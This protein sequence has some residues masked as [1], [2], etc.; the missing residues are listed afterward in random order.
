[1]V[2]ARKDIFFALAIIGILTVLLVPVP[3]MLMDLLLGVSITL[4]VLDPHDRVVRR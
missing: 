1:M 2:L 4:A 3:P